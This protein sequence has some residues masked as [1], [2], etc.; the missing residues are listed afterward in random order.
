MKALNNGIAY[1]IRI[2]VSDQN[3][4]PIIELRKTIADP[5]IIKEVISCAFHERPLILQPSFTDKIR[6]IN[7]LLEKGIIYKEQDG[8]YTFTF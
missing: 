6:A 3:G 7:S 8:Q 5:E 4:H 2:I 1:P